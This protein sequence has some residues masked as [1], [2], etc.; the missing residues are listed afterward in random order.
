MVKQFHERMGNPTTPEGKELLERAQP[1]AQ[2]RPDL[3][4]RC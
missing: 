2:G 1:A 3:P 4:S